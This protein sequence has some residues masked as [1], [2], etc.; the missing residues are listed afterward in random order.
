MGLRAH[1]VLLITAALLLGLY[2]IGRTFQRI[3]KRIESGTPERYEIY[4][5]QLDH[6]STTYQ[7]EGS[8]KFRREMMLSACRKYSKN[9]P[10]SSEETYVKNPFLKTSLFFSDEFKVLFCQIPKCA[11]RSQAKF[12]AAADDLIKE[13]E[14]DTVTEI[15]AT[16]L[17]E[18]HL[19]ARR[20]R[21]IDEIARRMSTYSKVVIV[22]EPFSRLLSAYRNKLENNKRG[23][24]YAGAAKNIH[25]KY[26]G[27]H[28]E[29]MDGAPVITLND[30]V[31]YLVDPKSNAQLDQ[32]WNYF[33]RLCS[34]CEI[35]YDYIVHVD[36]IDDDMAFIIN[37]FGFKNLTFPP[38]FNS[39]TD[40]AKVQKYFADVSPNLVESLYQTYKK[41]YELFGF[42]KPSEFQR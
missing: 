28:G 6:N 10:S 14:M 42:M 36:T 22:R 5:S 35:Q 33:H 11:T 20:I 18:K 13:S 15:R 25:K 26:G 1:K 37:K 4:R 9:R 39:F 7:A 2:L 30:F 21:N 27:G 3:Q 19:S 8:M 32:H 17:I 41:D 34:P 12:L 16:S 23:D 31:S 38:S 29:E 40:N 24:G